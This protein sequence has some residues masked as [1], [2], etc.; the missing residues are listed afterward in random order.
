MGNSQSLRS[1]AYSGGRWMAIQNIGLQ[2]LSLATTAVLAR[3]LSPSD[4]G[5]VAIVMVLL[6]LFSLINQVGWGAALVVRKQLSPEIVSTAFWAATV[7]GAAAATVLVVLAAPLASLFG[8]PAA[9]D[10]LRAIVIVLLLGPPGAVARALLARDLRYQAIALLRLT[11]QTTYAVTAVSLAAVAGLGVWSVI[12]GQVLAAAVGL[13]LVMVIARPPIRL[14]FRRKEFL[15]D[16]PFN[17]GF[18]GNRAAGYLGKNVD[19]WAVS[20]FLGD[21]PLGAYYIAYVAPNLVRQRVTQAIQATLFPLLARI[22]DD[23]ERLK[24]VWLESTEKA[25]LIVAPLMVGLAMLAD[26]II[27]VL[28]GSQWATAVGPMRILAVVAIV[29][30]IIAINGSVFT[31]IGKPHLSAIGGT[32]RILVVGSLAVPG[33]WL[34]GTAGVAWAV[35]GGSISVA[36]LTLHFL[37]REVRIGFGESIAAFRPLILPVA[38]MMASVLGVRAVLDLPGPLFELLLLVP[39]GT[40]AYFGTGFGVHRATFSDL[41]RDAFGIILGSWNRKGGA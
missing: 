40:V 39:L 9:T 41:G 36:V 37:R 20:K 7:F 31:A 1:A 5:L 16:L 19:Y 32:V 15:S 30:V 35:L 14:V 8:N 22:N 11:K 13:V 18:L 25:L 29:G 17:A 34:A 23:S 12:L 4:F 26:A 6:G 21:G 38:V 10:L 27:E 28:F 24:R 2:A 33:A 3:I